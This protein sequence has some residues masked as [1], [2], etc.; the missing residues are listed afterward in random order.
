M[1]VVSHHDQ[2]ANTILSDPLSMVKLFCCTK[3]DFC[4]P[5]YNLHSVT[6]TSISTTKTD[7]TAHKPSDLV[8]AS[9]VDSLLFILFISLFSQV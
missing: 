1:A 3:N 4:S 9:F 5:N 8:L 6:F 7:E 2:I